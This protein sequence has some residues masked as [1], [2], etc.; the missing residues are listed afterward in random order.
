MGDKANKNMLVC[1]IVLLLT[2]P[3][4]R[5]GRKDIFLFNDALNTF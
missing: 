4:S 3:S 5:I 2:K 1:F